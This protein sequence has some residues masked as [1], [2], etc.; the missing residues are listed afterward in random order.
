MFEQRIWMI[1][2]LLLNT[3]IIWMIF[4]KTLKVIIQIK[5][6]KYWSYL[7]VEMLIFL[8]IKKLNPIETELFMR[9]RKLNISVVFITQSYFTVPKSIRLNS[10]YYFII[11]I[12]NKRELLELHLIIHQILT[13]KASW[14]FTKNLLQNHILVQT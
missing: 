4:M 14:I 13:L 7:M 12:P 1:L 9:G 6:E 10:T 5:N 2:E 11:K 8:V 3:Q